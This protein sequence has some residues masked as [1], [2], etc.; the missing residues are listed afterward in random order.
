MKRCFT[1]DGGRD[2]PVTITVAT[3]K[4][5]RSLCDVDLMAIL[6]KSGALLARFMD[7][8]AILGDVLYVV[9]K[10]QA[11]ERQI[12]DE[13]FGELLA[14]DTLQNA[15]DVFLEALVDFFP[16][17]TRR[18]ALRRLLEKI[19]KVQGIVLDKAMTQ[20][21]DPE[22]DKCMEEAV[23]KALAPGASSTDA[24]GSS[25]SIPDP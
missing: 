3:V 23:A 12:T 8:P 18:K 5:V 21:E 6:D 13:Q 1:D 15:T 17:E 11:D 16:H 9:C 22:L 20:L 7:D 19:A 25:G 4:R 14:G 2:W 10:A 24:P